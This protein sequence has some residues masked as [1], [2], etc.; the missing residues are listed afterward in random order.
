ML[1]ELVALLRQIVHTF[2]GLKD[3]F[4]LKIEKRKF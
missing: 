1:G 3:L 4:L 2:I